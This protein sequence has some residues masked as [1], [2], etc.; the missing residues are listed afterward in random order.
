ML[1]AQALSGARES[2]PP[3][4]I[5]AAAVAGTRPSAHR[6]AHNLHALPARG[7]AP[8]VVPSHRYEQAYGTRN[9]P[10]LRAGVHA[11]TA[12]IF[13]LNQRLS[14]TQFQQCSPD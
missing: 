11:H 10:T 13:G 4:P 1:L 2:I 12:N 9:T 6:L 3:A 7:P 5:L 14:R 8:P